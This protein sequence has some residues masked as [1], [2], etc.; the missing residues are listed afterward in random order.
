MKKEIVDAI[1]ASPYKAYI[2]A[3]GGGST[4]IGEYLNFG[5]GSNTILKFDVPYNQA[6]FNEF[7]GNT[8]ENYKYVSKQSAFDL[9]YESFQRA[10]DVT[11]IE[12]SIGIGV[13]CSLKKEN[14]REGREHRVFIYG[15]SLYHSVEISLTFKHN[16][17]RIEEERIVSELMLLTLHTLILTV[18]NFGDNQTFLNS[19]ITDLQSD[20]FLFT[21]KKK[22]ILYTIYQTDLENI[23]NTDYPI[24]LFPGSFNPLHDGHKDMYHYATEL[25][26]DPFYELSLS[27]IEKKFVEN[28]DDRI[29]QFG[30]LGVPVIITDKAKIYD[31][32]KLFTDNFTRNKKIN[33]IFGYDTWIRFIDPEFTTP[34]ELEF[35][36]TKWNDNLSFIVFNRGQ[37]KEFDNHGFDVRFVH[38]FD[39]PISSTQ[40]R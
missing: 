20:D 1:N 10:V 30:C 14:E 9:G 13:T 39:N 22:E 34:E 36:K 40:L 17:T 35:L 5:G 29:N 38:D 26:L 2:T 18:E 31:K 15:E 24:T 33:F 3:T 32:I 11:S 8:G 6:F 19:T 21:F 23:N 4:F 16:R 12:H 28:L 27:N 7:V 25:G 37:Q